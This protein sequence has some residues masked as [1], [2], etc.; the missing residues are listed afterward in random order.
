MIQTVWDSHQ[1]EIFDSLQGKSVRLAGDGRC[2]SPGHSAKYGTYSLLD[3]DTDLVLHTEVVQVSEVKNSNAMEKEGLTRG[4]AFLEKKDI[5]WKQL[6][7]DRHP[8]IS[9][10]MA[11]EHADRDHEYDVWHVAKGVAKKITNA[12][13]RKGNEQLLEW[14]RSIVSHLWYAS[15]NCEGDADRLIESWLSVCHHVVNEHQWG[16]CNEI[17]HQ[18]DHEPLSPEEERERARLK[19]GS[20]AHKAIQDIIFN[21]RLTK[22]L[23]KMTG[24][25][26]TG[27]LEV[28]HSLMTKYVPKRLHFSYEGMKARTLLASLS[29]NFN[30]RKK[31]STTSEGKLRYEAVFPKQRKQWVVRPIQEDTDNSHIK[32]M[33]Q[34][35]LDMQASGSRIEY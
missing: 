9:A 14:K 25:C 24:F 8:Q 11:K 3:Q 7:T 32:E 17:V 27:S 6:A 23:R 18:C 10:Y 16:R 1:K 31:Q 19:K 33:L 4:L 30:V 12:G 35:A 26:H 22:D 20:P 21:K 29:H 2:D 13:K 34:L 5:T 28:F 15:K